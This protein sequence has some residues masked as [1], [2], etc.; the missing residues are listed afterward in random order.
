MLPPKT[1]APVVQVKI[2]GT[3][4][5]DLLR[6]SIVATNSFS[7][8]TFALTFAI[9]GLG[10][11]AI[12][13]WSSVTVE[14]VEIGTVETSLYG[15]EYTPLMTGMADMVQIDPIRGVAMV[16]GR[17]LSGRLVD[18]YRQQ[19]FVNQ[20]ASEIVSVVAGYHGLDPVVTP[21]KN[22]VGRYY[23]D[24]YTKLSLGQFSRSQ[25]DW[26]LVVQLAREVEFDV[27]VQGTS[28]YFRPSTVQAGAPIPVALRDVQSL[29]VDRNINLA[30][31]STAQVQSWNSR[32]MAAYSS[33]SNQ[34]SPGPG[35][36]SLP[37]L[38]SGANYTSEQAADVMR[39]F[40]AELGRLATVLRFEMPW[41][42]A[43]TP[44]SMIAV[45]GTG[46]VIDS[47]Y[48]VETVERRLNASTGSEQTVHASLI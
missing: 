22:S 46:S 2:D 9:G 41:D 27:F 11:E 3:P 14:T 30:I 21:T 28:L 19:D 20:T 48:R 45:T 31:N 34:I 10:Q 25:S 15:V 26:D 23:A 17:D 44:R 36:P 43:L 1:R 29:C 13:F 5:S 35:G 38:F 16:E 37:F 39:Q 4:V 18:S 8:D 47:V 7:A 32:D 24:G 6:A 40:T 33:S 42:L 12:D